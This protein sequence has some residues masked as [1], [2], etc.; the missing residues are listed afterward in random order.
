MERRAKSPAPNLNDFIN[1][2]DVDAYITSTNK[3]IVEQLPIMR[4]LVGA[5]NKKITAL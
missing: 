1:Y 3:P 2:T 5:Q 4:S